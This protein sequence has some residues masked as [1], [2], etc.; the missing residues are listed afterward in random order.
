MMGLV[1]IR[2]L[3]GCLG[4]VISSRIHLLCGFVV[5]ESSVRCLVLFYIPLVHTHL[6]GFCRDISKNAPLYRYPSSRGVSQ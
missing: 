4:F 1:L 5:F 6:V 2:A 3:G